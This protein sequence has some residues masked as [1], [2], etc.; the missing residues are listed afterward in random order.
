ML[1]RSVRTVVVCALTSNLARAD[2]P[3]NL[4]LDAGEGGLPRASVVVVSQ[5]AS[6]PRE[7][8]GVRLG[9]LTAGQVDRILEGLAFQQRSGAR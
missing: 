5:I 3:G 7:R 6:V 9:A 4:R 1:N 2:E 8:L